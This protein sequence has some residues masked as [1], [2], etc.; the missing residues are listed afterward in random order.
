MQDAVRASC[1]GAEQITRA[2][3]RLEDTGLIEAKHKTG[4][5][6][7]PTASDSKGNESTSQ[8]ADWLVAPAN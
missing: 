7:D 8:L 3:T 5:S 1:E 2:E 4:G 6:I